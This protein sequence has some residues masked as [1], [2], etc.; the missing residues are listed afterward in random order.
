MNKHNTYIK[1]C[2]WAEH[3]IFRDER[4]IFSE[5]FKNSHL[6]DLFKPV[7]SN[8]SFSKKGSLRGI[9]RTPYAKYVTCVKG[10]V[11]DVCVDLRKD[12]P[13]YGKYFSLLLNEHNLYSL[14]IPPYC[15]H[16]FLAITDS[17]LIYHQDGEYNP[18]LDETFCYK[19]YNIPWIENLSYIISLKDRACCND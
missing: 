5:I 13:T 14:Y 19:S 11:Y 4:G 12:S 3:N 16:A 9:H 10:E 15:G 7:Q 18:D 8:Y 6:N 1:D 17:V 2:F